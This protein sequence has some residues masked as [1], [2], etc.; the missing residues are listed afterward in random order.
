MEAPPVGPSSPS[1]L[2]S[3]SA[4]RALGGQEGPGF[5]EALKQY[6]D[7]VNELQQQADTAVVD[8]ATGKMENMHQV[9]AAV[10]EADLSFRLMMQVRNKLLDAYREIMR[11]QV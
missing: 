7:Q 1:P 9:V 4:R 3:E 10:T 11:M 5:K 8:L 6:V 2:G